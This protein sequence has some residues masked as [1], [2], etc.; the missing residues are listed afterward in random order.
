M[1][2]SFFEFLDFITV[3]IPVKSWR[4]HFRRTKTFNYRRKLNALKHKYPKMDWKHMRLAK[5]G[6]SLA[7]IVGDTVFKVRKYDN[8]PDIDTKFRREKRITDALQDVLPIQV[9]KIEIIK[10]G[11]Y[12]VYKTK[13]IPGCVLMDLPMKRIMANR[14]KIG[15]QIGEIMFKMFNAKLPELDD[16]KATKYDARDYGLIHGDMCSNI[17][18]NPETMDIVGIIDW[19]YASF[20]SLRREFFGIFRVRRKMRKTDI[21][22]IAMWHYLELRDLGKKRN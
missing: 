4:E 7:F 9:P 6:G 12:L 22:P 17:I 15:N 2:R 20:G 14:D 16:L 1:W 19:E 13:L 3:F 8:E 11:G 18:V 21:G 10:V 5:G